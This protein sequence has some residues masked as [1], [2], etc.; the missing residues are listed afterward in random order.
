MLRRPGG[1]EA[2]L[3]SVHV[4]NFFPLLNQRPDEFA[5]PGCIS[6]GILDFSSKGVCLVKPLAALKKAALRS[7]TLN[8]HSRNSI[9]N[10]RKHTIFSSPR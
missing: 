1:I 6:W 2:D 3:V 8:R 10:F 9:I 5:Y 7:S 4:T